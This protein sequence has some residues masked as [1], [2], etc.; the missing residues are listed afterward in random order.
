MEGLRRYRQI[1]RDFS[2]EAISYETY[3]TATLLKK[4]AVTMFLH[5]GHYI[6]NEQIGPI[7][8]RR[9][10][11]L[12]GKFTIAS[13]KELKPRPGAGEKSTMPPRVVTINGSPSFLK[14]LAGFSKNHKLGYKMVYLNGG[15]RR[16]SSEASKRKVPHLCRTLR[17]R[18]C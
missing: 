14:N 10:P 6:R 12:A 3:P 4:H 7:F 2:S 5:D 15:M 1:L 11:E 9:N 13:I 17:S 16:D 8:A 18:T